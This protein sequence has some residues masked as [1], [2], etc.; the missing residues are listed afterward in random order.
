MAT[1]KKL[2]IKRFRA[3]V[4]ASRQPGACGMGREVMWFSNGDESII[5]TIVVDIEDSSFVSIL[6]KRDEIRRY[7]AF[8]VRTGFKKADDAYAWAKQYIDQHIPVDKEGSE[9]HNDNKKIINLF[10]PVVAENKF[11]PFFKLLNESKEY[12]SAKGI[13]EEIM[14]HFVDIDGNYI[15][16][17]Q[18][19]GFD[20]R[21]WELY[22]NSYLTEEEFLFNREHNAP[23]FIVQ[24]HRKSIAI[25][26]AIVGK[27]DE[28]ISSQ[29][30]K[31]PSLDIK[32]K[33]KNEMPIR[34]GSVLYTKS[35]KKYWKLDHVKGLPLVMALADFHDDMSM[36]W[37]SSALIE[38]LY[39]SRFNAHHNESGDLIIKASPI[40]EHRLGEKVISSGY[41]FLPE[42]EYVSAILFSTEGTISKFIRMGKQAGFGD[43]SIS[44]SRKGTRYDHSPNASTPIPF[45]YKVN[46]E[47]DETWAQGLS[48][49]HNPKAL[50]PVPQK[51]FPSIA[52]HHFR[53]GEIVSTIPKFHSYSSL[54]LLNKVI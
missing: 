4:W 17:F 26:A 9:K 44:V 30:Y 3:L 33:I 2:D 1:I 13:I 28:V 38:Y 35:K 54:T 42:S 5:G 7:C 37:S 49:F 45:S 51:L 47:C 41:F 22:L 50:Y 23:D 24:K 20:A 27:K 48:M 8:E 46:E 15:E 31:S 11:H 12:S 10:L 39:G 52:H 36:L 21:L 40:E 29:G 25:E 16:Q 32:E 14:P 18:T 6:L 19:T 53:D 43:P 34:F